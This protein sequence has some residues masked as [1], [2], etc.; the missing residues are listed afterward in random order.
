MSVEVDPV[1][2]GWVDVTEG[3]LV[4]FAFQ[5]SLDGGKAG[6][7]EV[8]AEDQGLS[9]IRHS[10]PPRGKPVA[11]PTC[12]IPEVWRAVTAA[13]VPPELPLSFGY[14]TTPG[15]PRWRVEAAGRPELR[16]SVDG[17]TCKV[18]PAPE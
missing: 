5:Y 6:W 10:M 8:T 14:G 4:Y 17:T 16:R 7:V 3:G 1:V 2:G 12:S 18:V 11:R 9:A 15:A 13:G